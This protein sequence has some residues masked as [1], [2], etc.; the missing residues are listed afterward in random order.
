[1]HFIK[2]PEVFQNLFYLLGHSKEQINIPGT[3]ILD[4]RSSKGDINLEMVSPDLFDNVCSF[5]YQGPKSTKTVNYM[6]INRILSRLTKLN[7]S[8]V[9]EYCFPLY[10]L[11]RVIKVSSCQL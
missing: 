6:Y 4:W 8:S 9:K 10:L 3:N 5:R 2:F 11:L 7:E 1:M